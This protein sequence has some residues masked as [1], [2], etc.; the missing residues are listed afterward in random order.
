MDR[1]ILYFNYI[2]GQVPTPVQHADPVAALHQQTAITIGE[3]LEAVAQ[4]VGDK[5]GGAA[6]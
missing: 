1:S 6:K 5:Q 3:A 4:A 2:S